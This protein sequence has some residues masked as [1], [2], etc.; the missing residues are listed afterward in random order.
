MPE[1]EERLDDLEALAELLRLQLGRCLG[2]LLA[3]VVADLRQ[4]HRRQHLADRFGADAGGEAVRAVL[5]ERA[6]VL[7]LAKELPLA[8]GRDARLDDDV[9]LE[10]ENALEILE[11]HVEQQADARGQRLQEPDMGDGSGQLDV[12]HA[13]A[14]H[15]GERHLDAALFADE[16]LVLHPL[17]LAAQALVVL[18]RTEDARAEEA[19]AL[20]LERAV[21]DR[22]GLLNLAERP[23]QDVVRTRDGDLDLIEGRERRLRLEQVGNLVHPSLHSGRGG[24]RP[25][26]S[27]REPDRGDPRR[28]RALGV[29]EP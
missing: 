22:L 15:L 7:L 4:V 5:V 9:V 2:D 19:V 6:V 21:V 28:K 18:D 20:G 12:A 16:A 24:R 3:Q 13:L 23:R 17:V 10:I 8:E 11:R 1:L 27:L 25:V 26:S 29:D 14:A